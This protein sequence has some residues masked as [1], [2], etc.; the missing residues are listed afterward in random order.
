MTF[1]PAWRPSVGF[2]TSRSSPI[3]PVSPGA[4]AGH[5]LIGG[6]WA[7]RQAAP[8]SASANPAEV[9]LR[10][11]CTQDPPAFHPVRGSLRPGGD[12]VLCGPEPI[13]VAPCRVDV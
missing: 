9:L 1:R 12:K 7:P 13:A 11:V 2:L 5:S 8:R 6:D 3:P 10:L 4:A